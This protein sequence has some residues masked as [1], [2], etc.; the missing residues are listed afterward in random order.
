MGADGFRASVDRECP[1]GFTLVE[2]RCY[3]RPGARGS[4]SGDGGVVSR[5]GVDAPPDRAGGPT[6]VDGSIF[7]RDVGSAAINPGP[8]GGRDAAV[9]SAPPG[10]VALDIYVEGNGAVLNSADGLTCMDVV[11]HVVVDPG[12]R[13]SL[14][15]T[16]GEDSLFA[17]WSGACTGTGACQV[18]VD[19]NSAVTARFRQVAWQAPAVATE[20]AVVG[21]NVY[22]AGAFDGTMEIGGTS[23]TAVGL[24]DGFVVALDALTNVRWARGFGSPTSDEIVGL[25]R[26]PGESIVVAGRFVGD[27]APDV[28]REDHPGRC[29][30]AFDGV[31]WHLR[32]GRR[33]GLG[34]RRGL[35]RPGAGLAR[36]CAVRTPNITRATSSRRPSRARRSGPI[37]RA[38]TS[39]SPTWRS[40]GAT[41]P[42]SAATPATR[43]P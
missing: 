37:R 39:G 31:R 40:T 28:P 25:S 16:P 7:V 18:T 34:E 17:A 26:G 38:S 11:C 33:A 41:A 36:E 3:R 35:Q 27:A 19:R 21:D 30:Q 8:P 23:L 14:Q 24:T 1:P 42:S 20:L 22:V 29:G 2:D 43:S 6:G 32:P 15:P 10:R 9:G 4:G 13:V 12:T 5:P